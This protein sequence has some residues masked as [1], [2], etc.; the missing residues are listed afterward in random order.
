M[1]LVGLMLM[2]GCKK[3][4]VPTPELPAVEPTL[5]LTTEPNIAEGTE[6]EAGTLIKCTFECEGEKLSSL[7]VTI[8][9]EN[10]EELI[11]NLQ[12]LN[13]GTSDSTTMEYSVTYVGR[14]TMEA[15]LQSDNGKSATVTLHFTS[16]APKPNEKFLGDYDGTVLINGTLVAEIPGMEPVQQEFSEN[17]QVQVYITGGENDSIVIA[18]CHVNDRVFTATGIVEGNKIIANDLHDTFILNYEYNGMTFSPEIDVVY[19]LTATLDG[20]V[21]TFEGTY[22]GSGDTTILIFTGTISLDGTFNGS[23]NKLPPI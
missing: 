14:L 18:E 7:L 23:L 5:T 6:V 15:I 17:Y 4:P 9:R 11:H 20:D 1:V 10:G 19:S 3:D 8:T 22:K 2:T 21:L 12:T 16:V 13:G